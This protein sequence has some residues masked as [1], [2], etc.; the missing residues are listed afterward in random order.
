[1]E[2]SSGDSCPLCLNFG[3]SILLQAHLG[4]QQQEPLAVRSVRCPRRLA[5]CSHHHLLLLRILRQARLLGPHGHKK[6][7]NDFGFADGKSS[8]NDP[9]KTD[10][11]QD[12]DEEE[13]EEND[14]AGDEE[15]GGEEEEEEEGQE[16]EHEEEEE[17]D[18]P[19][20]TRSQARK[21]RPR[22]D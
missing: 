17:E 4:L 6:A 3:F 7:G 14:G 9:K 13:E 19:P 22:K 8:L 12:D 18:E 16:S 21:R 15:D 1:M 10:D 20:T 11:P 2:I 5:S